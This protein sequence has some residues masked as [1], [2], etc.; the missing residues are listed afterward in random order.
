MRRAVGAVLVVYVL[1]MAL[2]FMVQGCGG[3]S[4]GPLACELDGTYRA[5]A[6]SKTSDCRDW[7]VEL[8]FRH[9]YAALCSVDLAMQGYSGDVDCDPDSGVVQSCEGEI[10]NESCSYHLGVDRCEKG[11]CDE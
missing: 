5:I 2:A 7:S 4:P 1:A 11:L 6:V 3:F 9:Q 8:H 10:W